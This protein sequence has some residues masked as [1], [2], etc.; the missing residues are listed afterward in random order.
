MSIKLGK[1]IPC[2]GKEDLSFVQMERPH[3]FTLVDNNKIAKVHSQN[4]KVFSS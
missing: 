1:T 4:L 2:M 3:F